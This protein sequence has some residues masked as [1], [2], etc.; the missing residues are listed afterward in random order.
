[1][2]KYI[3]NVDVEVYAKDEDEASDIVGGELNLI[4]K[5]GVIAEFYL[6]VIVLIHIFNDSR[7][8]N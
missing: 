5:D 3:V 6:G 8:K 4:K 7:H 2:N 1:M